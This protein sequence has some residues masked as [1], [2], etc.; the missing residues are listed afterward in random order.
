MQM[1][2]DLLGIRLERPRVVETTAQG[3]AFMAGLG[4][5]LWADATQL[6]RVRAVDRTFEPI[7]TADRRA[8]ARA[9][10]KRAV[11][12]SRAWHPAEERTR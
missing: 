4:C 2:S 8:E 5:G 3:A 6:N 1:Q 9:R 7:W 10:W 11:E 12:C